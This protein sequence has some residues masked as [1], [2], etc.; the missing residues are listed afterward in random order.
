MASEFTPKRIRGTVVT[1]L[2]SAM[3]MGGFVG[4]LTAATLIPSYGWKALFIVGGGLPLVIALAAVRLLPE[5]IAF[6]SMSGNR[7][8]CVELLRALDPQASVTADAKYCVCIR[9][10]AGEGVGNRLFA[11]GRATATLAVWGNLLHQLPDSVLLDGLDAY[12]F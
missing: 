5:S 8:K 9:R 12:A 3:S 2:V 10:G 11:P 1:I 7:E 6:V 4:G